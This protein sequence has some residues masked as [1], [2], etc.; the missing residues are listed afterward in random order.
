MDVRCLF[1]G[2][3]DSA[4]AAL[5]LEPHC[6]LTLV[7]CRFGTD[8]E[9]A[10][11][12]AAAAL[13]LPLET[14]ALDGSELD[15]A[16]ATAVE[17]GYPRNAIQQIHEH[18]LATVAAGDVDFV[19]DGT[20][21]DDR[22][23]TVPRAVAQRIEDRHGVSHLAPLAGIGHAAVAT[24][25]DALL[26]VETGPSETLTTGD[27]EAELRAT[28]AAEYGTDRVDAIFP[29]HEQSRVVGRGDS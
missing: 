25:Q 12:E 16:V 17:D 10:A 22:T 2:G 23:P 20:R 11:R 7:S 9:R 13:D 28:I 29:A 5:L 15:A 27:Y 26:D 1:S 6:D 14:V 19:A 18:A 3:A 21:R 4:L 8:E 24:L